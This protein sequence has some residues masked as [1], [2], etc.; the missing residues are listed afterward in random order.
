MKPGISR[1]VSILTAIIA[2]GLL[3]QAHALAWLIRW[4]V[5]GMLFV[6]FLQTRLS[7]DALQRSHG[8][9]LAAN[10]ATSRTMERLGSGKHA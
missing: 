4:L 10:L 1:T 8:V 9:L 7:R 5:I 6:V 3:P 2:G